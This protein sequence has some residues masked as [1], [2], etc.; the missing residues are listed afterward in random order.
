MIVVSDFS[1]LSGVHRIFCSDKTLA[2]ST[3]S[4]FSTRS[5]NRLYKPPDSV[6]SSESMKGGLMI[7]PVSCFCLITESSA[8]LRLSFDSAIAFVLA[9]TFSSILTRRS[10]SSGVNCFSSSATISMVVLVST[11]VS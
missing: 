4:K 9:E 11:I 5:A 6:S 1:S 2:D 8:D 7:L 10:I 3:S